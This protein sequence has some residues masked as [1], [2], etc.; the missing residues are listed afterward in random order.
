MRER[1]R[2][3]RIPENAPI[4]YE[5]MDNPETGEHFTKDISLGGIRFFIH[6]FVPVNSFLRIKLFLKKITFYFEALVR[7]VWIRRDPHGDRYEIGVEFIN[8]P[9]EAVEHLIEYIKSILSSI[10][11]S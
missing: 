10:G 9:Q 1:R 3:I 5:I 2:F 8:I 6:H 4:T 7:V 11:T